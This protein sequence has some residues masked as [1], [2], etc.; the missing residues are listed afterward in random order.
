MTSRTPCMPRGGKPPAFGT[1]PS[2]GFAG[3]GARVLF[4]CPQE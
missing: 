1:E 2:S 4:G 3:D